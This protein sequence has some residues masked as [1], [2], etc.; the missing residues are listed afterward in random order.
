MLA[1]VVE[2]HGAPDTLELRE[3]PDPAPPGPHEVLIEV[4]AASVNFPDLMVI[5]GTYQNLPAV[6][7]V[8]GKDLAGRVI[9]VGSAVTR[10][11]PDDRVLAHVEHGAFAQRV[12]L[13]EHRCHRMPPSM[14]WRQGA[15][16]GLVYLTAHFALVERARLQPAEV[17]LVTGASGGVG[18]AA[19]QIARALGA[20]V[21]AAV[22]SEEKAQFMRAQ[23]A[24]H[25]VRTDRTPLREQV[26][27][28]VGR[29][30]V[31]VVV[32]TVGGDV[33]DAC[34]RTLAWCGRLV[35]VG[36]AGGRIPEVKAG[37]LLVKNISLL[38]L[39][40]SDYRDRTPEQ[41]EQVQHELYRLFERGAIAPQIMSTVP[42]ADYRRAL[43][44]V[45]DRAV[46]GKV[47]L[48]MQ[49]AVAQ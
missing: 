3:W 17:V 16:M 24:D 44:A 7:F 39:Q 18:L 34:L 19:V 21:I 14:S 15:A 38:G 47:V 43:R 12:T 45:Q 35:I 9:A 40:V 49:A 8:P 4:H 30:G 32:D 22:G 33:F 48:D 20:V 42:L 13:A 5:A 27:A 25:V 29:R 10:V 1:L 46:L 31:D 6:P 41:V 28:A 23:G 2:S 11:R 37:L 36:F 26:H